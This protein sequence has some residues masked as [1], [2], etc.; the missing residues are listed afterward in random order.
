MGRHTL[1]S[2]TAYR[3][4]AFEERHAG[5]SAAGQPLMPISAYNSR[6][7][8]KTSK[9]SGGRFASGFAPSGG[10]IEH[11]LIGAFCGKLNAEWR[12]RLLNRARWV[13]ALVLARAGVRTR[14]ALRAYRRRSIRSAKACSAMPCSSTRP[15]RRRRRSVR[16]RDPHADAPVQHHVRRPLRL[17]LEQPDHQ[18]H[19]HRSG[20]VAGLFAG[21]RRDGYRTQSKAFTVRDRRRGGYLRCTYRIARQLT[22]SRDVMVYASL[23]RRKVSSRAASPFCRRPASTIPT[24]QDP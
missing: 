8:L 5:R 6:P 23:R 20:A 2:I 9:F 15:T 11:I 4:A 7:V 14:G 1:T 3:R 13:R 24:I 16:D 12:T 17:R 21:L 19:Q 18:L 10:P 22:L